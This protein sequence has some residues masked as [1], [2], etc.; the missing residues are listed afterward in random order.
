MA[1]RHATRFVIEVKWFGKDKWVRSINALLAP[2]FPTREKAQEALDIP[3]S[4]SSILEYR[5]RQK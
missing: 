2:H 4:K 5:I 3:G 1:G